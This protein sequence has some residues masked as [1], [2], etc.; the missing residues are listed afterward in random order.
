MLDAVYVQYD[1]HNY[2]YNNS[3]AANNENKMQKR[4][5]K[6]QESKKMG[7]IARSTGINF[8]H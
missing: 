6:T 3:E 2:K 4:S 1:M 7:R 5:V 8:F